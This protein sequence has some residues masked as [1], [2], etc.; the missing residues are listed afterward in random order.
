MLSAF[1]KKNTP[2][3]EDILTEVRNSKFHLVMILIDLNPLVLQEKTKDGYTLLHF[4]I[5]IAGGESSLITALLGRLEARNGADKIPN[6][7]NDNTILHH[8]TKHCQL[9]VIK[10]LLKLLG[11]KSV[12]FCQSTNSLGK[13][14][15]LLVEENP[16]KDQH[17]AIKAALLV[18]SLKFRC[19]PLSHVINENEVLNNFPDEKEDPQS[20]RIIS[21]CV[22][23]ANKSRKNNL[24]SCTHPQ[25]ND[26][27]SVTLIENYE[28]IISARKQI[29]K[30]EL[31]D[32]DD[33]IDVHAKLSARVAIIHN[34]KMGNCDE[35]AEDTV[36]HLLNDPCCLGIRID[37]V[38]LE[39]NY[40]ATGDHVFL[41]VHRNTHPDKPILVDS[42]IGI[43]TRLN[44]GFYSSLLSFYRF[45]NHTNLLAYPNKNFDGH[46]THILASFTNEQKLHPPLKLLTPADFKNNPPENKDEKLLPKFSFLNRPKPIYEVEV[47]APLFTTI[48]LA[49]Q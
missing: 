47:T 10:Y 31:N 45:E 14:P 17:E 8:V 35:V 28:K 11:D 40:G 13:T 6:T 7:P 4:I 32:D 42:Y 48:K 38:Y 36:N 18:E 27:D 46:N 16:F 1:K 25:C 30:I 3:I 26:I 23:A 20:T 2:G 5:M 19:L 24:Y 29:T 43:I 44:T 22:K 9:D 12:F 33:N 21:A 15:L 34:T 41:V 49:I 39:E 37:K